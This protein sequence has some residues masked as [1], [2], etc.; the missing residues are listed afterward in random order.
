MNRSGWWIAAAAALVAVAAFVALLTRGP[1][2]GRAPVKPGGTARP[3]GRGAVGDP[4]PGGGVVRVTIS[5]QPEGGSPEW[6]LELRDGG[7]TVHVERGTGARECAIEPV[8]G[9]RALLMLR[10]EGFVGE[11][12][13]LEVGSPEVAAS[14]VLKQ[15][16]SVSGRLQCDGMPVGAALVRLSMARDSLPMLMDLAEQDRVPEMG[17][18]VES[19]AEG[20]YRFDRVPP[21]EGFTLVAADFDHAPAHAGPF[22]VRPGEETI[23]DV[24][25][26]LGSHLAG[27]VVDSRGAPCVGTTVHVY[28]KQVK[29]GV[30]AWMDE[31]R[32]RTDDDGRFVTPAL[33]GLA[34]RMLKAWVAVDGVQEIIQHETE[35]PERGTKDVG[36]LAPLPGTVLFEAESMTG[37]APFKVTVS[38]NEDPPGSGR[39]VVVSDLVLDREG[40]VRVTG[41]PVGEGAY[42][43]LNGDDRSVA[44]GKFRTTGRDMVVKL[45]AL[46]EPAPPAPKPEERLVIEVAETGED[47]IVVLIGEGEF[48]MWREVR[49]DDRSPVIERVPPGRYTLHVAAGDRY[50]QQ[51]VTQV[52]GQDLKLSV[53]PDRI[54]RSLTLL[55]L[56]DG[57]PVPR[58]RVELR[59]FRAGAKGLRA[60][61]AEG[62]ED[63]RVVLRGLPAGVTVLSA[64]IVN[65]EGQGRTYPAI[66]ITDAG[67]ATVDLAKAP[68]EQR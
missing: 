35:P 24:P 53:I 57:K 61:W 51:E 22:D 66:E 63:G 8:A 68:G 26:V 27:R 48:L 54:G 58:A 34:T 13:R 41:L 67:E 60:P 49:K 59:G 64:T 37:K 50:S 39:G 45:P 30:F 43:V 21:A 62:G 47:A 15:F 29:P 32:A 42:T 18:S 5:V 11:T 12:R 3:E 6:T 36:T 9:G 52:K 46:V 16:G 23:V 7:G 20:R 19:D 25:M 31:A 33:A 4:P 14:A 65:K 28:Q 1:A 55:V 2:S 17:W 10:A 40:R 44:D 56:Q 38:V